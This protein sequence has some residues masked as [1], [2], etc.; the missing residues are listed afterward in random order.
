MPISLHGGTVK[1]LDR[2]IYRGDD[3]TATST[4]STTPATTHAAVINGYGGPETLGAAA[5][6]LPPWTHTQGL[7][8]VAAATV[9]PVDLTTREGV[10]IPESEARFP[11]VLGWDVAG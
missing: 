11:M 2:S 6:P 8:D 7:V 5:G 3:M 1:P 4:T 9:N 10:S